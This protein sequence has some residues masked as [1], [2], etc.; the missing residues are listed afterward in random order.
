LN[1]LA[2]SLR[3]PLSDYLLAVEAAGQSVS[4]DEKAAL[5]TL[6]DAIPQDEPDPPVQGFGLYVLRNA[7]RTAAC[8]RVG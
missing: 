6:L 4:P 3:S 2:I 7:S 1:C 8:T 5:Q